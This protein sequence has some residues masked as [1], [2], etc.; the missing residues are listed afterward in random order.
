V[1]EGGIVTQQALIPTEQQ[2]QAIV[3]FVLDGLDSEHSRRAYSKALTDFLAWY[4]Q[5]G[6]P[7]LSKRTVQRYKAVLAEEGLSPSTVNL[8]LSAIRKLAQEAADNG[9]LDLNQAAAIGRIKGVKSAGVRLGN[10]LDREQA[11]ALI[12][13]PNLKTLKGARD[14]ALLAVLIGTGIR[15][16]EAAALTFEHLQQREGRWVIV[17]LIGKGKRVRSVPMPSWAKA[18]VDHWAAKAGLSDGCIFRSF[19]RGG[20]VDGDSMTPQAIYD[21]VRHYADTLG[22]DV[23]AHDTRRTY[24]KLAEKGGADL[25]QISLSLGHASIKTT[26]AYLGTEQDLVDAPC[27]H[28][29]LRL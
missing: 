9:L 13:A 5:Q 29:G 14:R 1:Q 2:Q 24:A 17:N 20:R 19:H 4:T 22:L 28:L 12:N 11:Q 8:R 6:R 3:G 27:D 21:V 25:R 26:E 23:A 10:W 16:S 18:A 15:R 7:G